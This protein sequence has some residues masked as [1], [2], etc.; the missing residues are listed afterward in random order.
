MYFGDEYLDSQDQ[1]ET[2]FEVM[3]K[4][5]S[6]EKLFEM[7]MRYELR[8]FEFGM[9]D[10]LMTVDKMRVIIWHNQLDKV[11]KSNPD[12]YGNL[13]RERLVEKPKPKAISNIYS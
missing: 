8:T 6:N 3:K 10:A 13:I 12:K 5:M 9:M 11:I 2:N 7:C 1:M 4:V